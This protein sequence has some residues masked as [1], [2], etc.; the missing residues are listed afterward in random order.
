[1][2]TKWF[3][4]LHPCRKTWRRANTSPLGLLTQKVRCRVCQLSV[5]NERM[6]ECHEWRVLL[7]LARFNKSYG[8]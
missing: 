7:T 6:N 3:P 4:P 8:P 1:L 2:P 5:V